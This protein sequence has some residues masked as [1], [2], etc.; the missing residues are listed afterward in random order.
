MSSVAVC[1]L[2]LWLGA[3]S[4]AAGSLE[5]KDA[6]ALDGRSV[7]QFRAIE[8]RT[9]PAKPL[10]GDLAFGEGAQHGLLPVGLGPETGLAIVWLPHAARGPELWLD[11]DGDGRLTSVERHALSGRELE[12]PARITVQ[13]EPEAVQVERTLVFRR[14]SLGDG[15]RYAVRGYAQGSIEIGGRP[16]ATV[17]IDGNADGCFNTVGQDRLWIDLDHDGRFDAITEQFPL[18][19][20][21]RHEGQT[22]VVRSDPL[23]SSVVA[24]LRSAEQGKL[25]LTLAARP[26]GNEK[27]RI[28]AQLLSDLGELVAIDQLDSETDV[29]TGEYHVSS[30]QLEMPDAAGETWL[31]SFYKDKGPQHR[32]QTGQ[33]T[34]IVL[35]PDLMMH[36]TLARQVGKIRPGDNVTITPRLSASD[37]LV[38]RSCKVG[39]IPGLPPSRTAAEILLLSLDGRPI[40]RGVSGFS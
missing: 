23:A 18:G 5:F 4:Q 29:P 1:C 21:L 3:A 40:S 2:G 20:P 38:L 7:L 14:A 12:L 33:R 37:G 15:L 11:A 30:L 35:L 25:C 32:V 28:S 8:F 10:E 17:L 19:K 16:H 36:V 34:Q 39:K 31:Y 22:Y 26:D 13:L 6:A 27:V 24:S 9:T